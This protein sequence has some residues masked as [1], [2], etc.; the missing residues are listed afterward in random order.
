MNIYTVYQI[1]CIVNGKVYI[2][3][4][5]KNVEDRFKQHIACS[6]A[7]KTKFH[8]AIKKH[9][10]SNFIVEELYQ[11]HDKTHAGRVEDDMILLYDS[12]A[13]GYNTARGGQGGCI[14]LFKENPEYDR[15]C[16]KL[17]DTRKKQSDF[18]RTLAYTRHKRKDVGMYGKTHSQEAKNAIGC[19]HKGKKTSD[20][21][22]RKQRESLQRTF[23]DPSYVHPNTGTPRSD[24][25]KRKI[26]LTRKQLPKQ[27]CPH[28]HNRFDPANYARYHGDKCKLRE[29]EIA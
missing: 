12:I 23:S 22:K 20:D 10:P 21:Q 24:D 1:K 25:V 11:T 28:C 13:N 26:S 18:Y 2:G 4:T 17:S 29:L 6:V 19:A 27:S 16:Q 15:I 8:R 14:A 7:P 9:A 5:S 3:Y